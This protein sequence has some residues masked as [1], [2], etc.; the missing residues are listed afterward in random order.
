MDCCIPISYLNDF[1]FCPLSIYYHQL[2]G[3]LSTILY[4]DLPQ[5]EGR[6]AHDTIDKRRYST[7]KSVLQGIEIYSS[8]YNLCGK[9]DLF[10][11]ESGVLTERKKRIV[12][13]YDG[14]VFQL[15]AQYY[16]LT[17]MGYCVRELRFYSKDDNAVHK[18]CL[19]EED[20]VMKDAFEKVISDINC[21]QMD[22]F[23]PVNASKCRRCIYE[24]LCDRSLI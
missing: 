4:Q 19:P 23:E 13:V 3:N 10:D 8:R 2:Y 20:L 9:I 12:T 21:F 22:A 16:G 1:I 5:I 18:V 15:Y 24:P 14:Y 7:R 17:E 6:A 11:I